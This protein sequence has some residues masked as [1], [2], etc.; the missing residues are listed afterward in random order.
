M[1]QAWAWY[2]APGTN[3]YVVINCK[4][5]AA[6]GLTSNCNNVIFTGPT[7]RESVVNNTGTI[8]YSTS[9]GNTFMV[10][11]SITTPG[12]VSTSPVQTALGQVNS[13]WGLAIDAANN[14]LYVAN[15]GSNTVSSCSISGMTLNCNGIPVAM[16]APEQINLNPAGNLLYIAASNGVFF[17]AVSNGVISQCQN[18]NGSGYSN[19]TSVVITP[20]NQYAYISVGRNTGIAGKLYYCSICTTTSGTCPNGPGSFFNCTQTATGTTFNGGL[21]ALG[22]APTG[23]YIYTFDNQNLSK[24][25]VLTANGSVTATCG[26]LSTGVNGVLGVTIN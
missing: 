21:L 19:L 4:V 9:N 6:N 17:C 18:T 15:N 16:T 8:L 12:P 10:A 11:N 7:V 2:T 22:I 23:Q 24:Q 13:G 3:S 5:I 14:Y 20:N 1:V 25:C 26:G